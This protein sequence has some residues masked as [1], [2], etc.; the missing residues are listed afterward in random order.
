MT[1]TEKLRQL[2]DELGFS[3]ADLAQFLGISKHRVF[4]M[5]SVGYQNRIPP[6]IIRLLEYEL[7]I[8]RLESRQ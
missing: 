5:L 1:D 4:N 2:M 7:K 3:S 6:Y 8:R